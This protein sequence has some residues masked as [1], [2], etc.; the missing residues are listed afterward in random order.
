MLDLNHAFKSIYE[1]HD[2]ANPSFAITMLELM[3]DDLTDRSIGQQIIEFLTVV[4][5]IYFNDL[6]KNDK[7]AYRKK[8]REIVDHIFDALEDF[9]IPNFRQY[10]SFKIAGTP[11]TNE[12]FC[13]SLNGNSYGANM[14]PKNISRGRVPQKS[15]LN[16]FYFCNATAGFLGFAGAF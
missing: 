7:R 4:D 14:T 11:T 1:D 5:Y 15:S 9:Y 16:G 2:Y 3:T 12:R 8:K 10:I 6:L 13:G